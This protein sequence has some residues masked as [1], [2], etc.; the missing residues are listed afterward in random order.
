LFEV[1]KDLCDD[2]RIFDTGDNLEHTA[3]MLTGFNVNIEY[4]L[5]PLSPCHRSILLRR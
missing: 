2:R 3:A 1:L 4:S 5:Q